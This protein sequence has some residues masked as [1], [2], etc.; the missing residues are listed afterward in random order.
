Y[1]IVE[2]FV[3]GDSG[4]LNSYCITFERTV[5][6]AP[7]I[8]CP[9]DFAAD[10]DEGVCGAV[11]N[12]APPIAI[13]AE[14][15]VLDPSNVVQ[16]GGITTGGFFPV[17]DNLVTFTATD[18]HL[19]ETSC[20]FTIT[21]LDTEDTV[22]VC[23]DITVTLDASGNGSI[24]AADLDGGS[25]DNCA[26]TSWDA[27]QTS[28]DCSDVGDVTVTLTVFDD[29]GN[30]SSCDATVTVVDDMAPIVTCI[31]APGSST[32][33]EG[34]EGASV[35]AGW[36]T[37]IVNGGWDWTFGS[38]SMPGTDDFPTNAAIFDDDAA[39]GGPN[40]VA[41]L[42]SPVYDMT[43][44]IGA[45]LSFDYALGDYAG[46]GLLRVEVYDGAAWQ[47]VFLADDAD[48]PPTNSGA[49]DVFAY[50]N[51]NFQVQFTYDDENSGWNWGAG[52]DNFSLTVD[53]PPAPPLEIALGADGMASIPAGDLIINVDE[54]C[55]YTVT[56]G[57]TSACSQSNPGNGFENGLFN[58]GAPFSVANDFVANGDF[59]LTQISMNLFHDIGA[60]IDNVVFTYYEDAAG[61]P[62]AVIGTET[63]VPTSQTVVGSNF[64]FDVSDV[65]FDITPV[66]F[67]DVSGTG[68]TYWVGTLATSTSGGTTAW[69]VSTAS[70]LG[71]E[72]TNSGDGGVTWGPGG[73]GDGVYTFSGVCGGTDPNNFNFDCSNLGENVV[74]VFVTDNSGNTSSCFA[75]VV[76]V[77][78][79]APVLVCQDTT[80]ELG[81]DG[82]ATVDPLDLLLEATD[83]CGIDVLIADLEEVS[84]ADIGTP[85]DVTVLAT[86]ANGNVSSCTL[87]VTVVDTM[88][89]VISCPADDSIELDFGGT[90]SL[91]DYIADGSATVTD[92]CTDPVTIF[93]QDPV[94]GTVLGFGVHTITFTAEDEYGNVA[95]CS[96]ELTLTEYLSNNDNELGNAVS[97]YPNPARNLV[98]ITNSSN[99][100]LDNAM[101]YDINGKLIAQINL[102]EM[103]SEKVID[104]SEFATGVYMVQ[105]TGEQA[106]VVKRLIKK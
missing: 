51:A 43:G 77:D 30:A 97:M 54:A 70:S 66:D 85:I 5:G 98:T 69:E 18:S 33:T 88:A 103:Q 62:G 86:D 37:I 59:T 45:T 21:I 26:V 10:N 44:A 6:D 48:I 94:A 76:I 68:T 90:H 100:S 95:T 28:F 99:I 19:N 31:G 53:T 91:G 50:A 72:A 32:Y 25:T 2:D 24:V 87:V 41:S 9:A 84:C 35:P 39:G 73:A 12:F 83:N 8:F 65:V 13:D 3:G 80:I 106:S 104:V 36:S 92:N 67:A 11:V 96:F 47:E 55:G 105:I 17:G 42:L 64:G 20:S 22:A 27:D 29:A 56:S 15:G 82:T 75:T 71:N 79:I 101:M 78:T 74:E 4:T 46:S 93:T 14:D 49:I 57:G 7:E 1:V 38:N 16:T 23:Q 81:E 58:N 40:H 89:P 34:F 63:A 52:V 102:Q 60:T 61:L